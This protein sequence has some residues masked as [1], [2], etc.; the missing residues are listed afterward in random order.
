VL[1]AE[2][3]DSDGPAIFQTCSIA[4]AGL[5]LTFPL[6]AGMV[7]ALWYGKWTNRI[8]SADEFRRPMTLFP[9]DPPVKKE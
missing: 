7:L 9:K 8:P 6:L 2:N 5:L 4:A 1:V 3:T